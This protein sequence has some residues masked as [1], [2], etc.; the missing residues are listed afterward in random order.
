MR[1]SEFGMAG[2]VRNSNSEIRI[3][4]SLPISQRPDYIRNDPRRAFG[5]FLVDDQWGRQT[6]G[7]WTSAE[8]QQPALE[9]FFDDGVAEFRSR[10]LDSDHEAEAP[11][12][13]NLGVRP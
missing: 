9:A 11:D 6:N 10:N 7:R 8:E 12:L 2:Y 1:I 3:P 13:N 4:D 5:L